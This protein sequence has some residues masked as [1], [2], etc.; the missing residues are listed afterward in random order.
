MS[1]FIFYQIIAF[2]IAITVHEAA[3]A[4]IAYKCGDDTAYKE[5]RISLNPKNHIEP[6]GTIFI[7]L[8]L[9]FLGS[10]FV[11]G[12]AKPVPVDIHQLKDPKTDEYWIALAGPISNLFTAFIFSFLTNFLMHNWEFLVKYHIL[13]LFL[14]NSLRDLGLTIIAINVLLAVF[15]LIPIPPLDGFNI[16]K[17]MLPDK[18]Y[19]SLYIPPP[20]GFFLFLIL[21]G[22][23]FIDKI[24]V[25]F[26]QPIFYF[27][28]SPKAYINF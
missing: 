14:I 1:I 9:I 26:Y 12:W 10:K 20:V 11:F 22:T 3:H 25:T 18:I 4:Y 15:N 8:F 27:L 23:G 17:T 5:G 16:V 28:I 6:F 19:E 2:I 13:P 7:P 21:L 24:I